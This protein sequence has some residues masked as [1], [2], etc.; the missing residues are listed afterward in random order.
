MPNNE[1][2]TPAPLFDT[3]HHEFDFTLDAAATA[4]NAKCARYFSQED[5]AFDHPWSAAERVWLNPPYGRGEL[6]RW[7]AYAKQ[8][9]ALVVA[10]IPADTSTTWWHRHI[11]DE[12]G[13]HPRTGVSVRFVRG[14]VKFSDA[15]TGAKFGSAVV[16]FW[17]TETGEH[18]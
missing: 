17:G 9:P 18:P 2:T 7:L 15:D 11:W 14:R 3:L 1:H 8:Q 6:D 4:A 13:H 5:S 10:L 12:V 16:I